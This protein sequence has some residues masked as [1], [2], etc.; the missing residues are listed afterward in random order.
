MIVHK[1]GSEQVLE[2]CLLSCKI[3]GHYK[4]NN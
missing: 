1:V 4:Y 3:V 2:N